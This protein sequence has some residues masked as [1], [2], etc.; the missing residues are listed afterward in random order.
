MRR[1]L[2]IS[3]LYKKRSNTIVIDR[4]VDLLG[5][6]DLNGSW[7]IWGNSS[8]GKT[9]FALQLIKELSKYRKAVYNSLEQGY[10]V[11][12]RAA[13]KRENLI[14]ARSRI[15]V[16]NRESVEDLKIRL[17][18]QKSPGIIVI[19]SIQYTGLNYQAYKDII[20][21]FPSKLFIWISHAEGKNPRG[22]TAQRIRYD[23][24]IKISVEGFIATANS[25]FG[26][27]KPYIISQEKAIEYYGYLPNQDINDE[28]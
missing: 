25:R 10:S 20:Q 28:Y 21:Q 26:G 3:D 14:D 17:Q 1:A 27:G 8:A 16:L 5:E 6:V 23:A 24:D 9:S 15:T 7:I 12:M 22:Q 4:F 18:K 2:S 13:I 11:S 19:D